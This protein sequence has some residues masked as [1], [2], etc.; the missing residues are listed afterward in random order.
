MPSAVAWVRAARS[1]PGS[2]VVECC[3]VDVAEAGVIGI[4]DQSQ[5]P[6]V[7]CRWVPVHVIIP[8]SSVLPAIIDRFARSFKAPREYIIVREYKPPKRTEGSGTRGSSSAWQ[9]R[10]SGH[11]HAR[12]L[13]RQTCDI[14]RRLA[15]VVGVTGPPIADIEGR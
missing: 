7:F 12:L 6:G 1:R 2:S 3:A 5:C 14:Q 10:Q 11:L 9:F 8:Q 13:H 4:R 15:D